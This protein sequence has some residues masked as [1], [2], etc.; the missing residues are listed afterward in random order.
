MPPTCGGKVPAL[1]RRL[2][3]QTSVEKEIMR[4]PKR[5]LKTNTDIRL[6]KITTEN[7]VL[8]G[9]DLCIQ[10]FFVDDDQGKNKNSISNMIR[11]MNMKKLLRKHSFDLL[12]RFVHRPKDDCMVKAVQTNTGEMIGYAEIFVCQLDSGT[13]R[14][15]VERTPAQQQLLDVDGKIY[16]PKIANLAGAAYPRSIH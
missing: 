8:N 6:E 1:S 15:Y 16:M 12:N 4:F 13:Y 5:I 14:S 3:L 11:A 10:V 9:A 7:D 2:M